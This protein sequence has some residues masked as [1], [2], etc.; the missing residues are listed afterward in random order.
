MRVI[1]TERAVPEARVADRIVNLATLLTAECK[2]VGLY[3]GVF[4][5]Q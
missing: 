1:E 5:G 3:A 4:I 2:G